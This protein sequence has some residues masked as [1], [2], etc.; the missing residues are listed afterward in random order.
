MRTNEEILSARVLPWSSGREGDGARIEV[1]FGPRPT[2]DGSTGQDGPDVVLPEL[3][4]EARGRPVEVG[5]ELAGVVGGCT[6]RGHRL[7]HVVEPGVSLRRADGKRMAH[8][9][10]GVPAPLAV[11][12]RPSPVLDEELRQVEPRGAEVVGVEGPEHRIVLDALVEAVH[13]GMEVLVAPHPL[14]ERCRRRSRIVRSHVQ[15]I[16]ATTPGIT[17]EGGC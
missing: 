7:A 14:V 8:P 17:S 13:E 2:R 11:A 4:D 3:V 15:Q 5:E 12:T 16:I 1:C 6:A 9:Q 10:A